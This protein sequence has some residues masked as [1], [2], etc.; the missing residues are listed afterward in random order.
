MKVEGVDTMP[1]EVVITIVDG[2]CGIETNIINK[3]PHLKSGL[4]KVLKSR[5]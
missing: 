5:F 4:Q 1:D 3:P 2:P